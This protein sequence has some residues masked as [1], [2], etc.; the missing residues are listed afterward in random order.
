MKGIVSGEVVC[1]DGVQWGVG[2]RVN[3]ANMSSVG[4]SSEGYSNCR[5]GV[6]W[7]VGL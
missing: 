4:G 3:S 1:R 2:L 6:Q 7:G 5:G